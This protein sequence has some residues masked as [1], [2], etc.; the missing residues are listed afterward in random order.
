MTTEERV[1][2]KILILCS[3]NLDGS[4][5]NPA[6]PNGRC[7]DPRL[8][9]PAPKPPMSAAECISKVNALVSVK[10]KLNPLAPAFD[11]S[12][13]PPNAAKPKPTARVV[14][15]CA[16]IDSV[17]TQTQWAKFLSSGKIAPSSS[18]EM[19][20]TVFRSKAIFDSDDI[21]DTPIFYSHK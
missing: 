20:L 8:G 16:S 13:S 17:E 10:Q 2:A 19:N 15:N 6:N 11:G 18:V 7:Y 4:M 9:L 14:S 12:R 1:Q 5:W 21:H 3:A